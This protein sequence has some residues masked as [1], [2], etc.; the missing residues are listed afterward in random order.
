[1]FD[2]P[3]YTIIDGVTLSATIVALNLLGDAIRETI[4]PLLTGRS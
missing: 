2:D 3:W 1:M 4:D